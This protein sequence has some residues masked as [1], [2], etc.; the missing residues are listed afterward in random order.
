MEYLD[1][2]K[3]FD[4]KF[5]ARN[6]KQLVQISNNNNLFKLKEDLSQVFAF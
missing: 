2:I 5:R 1:T 3:V 6:A 4:F